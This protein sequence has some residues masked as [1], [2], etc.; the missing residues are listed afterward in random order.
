MTKID[1]IVKPK[2][3]MNIS[4]R[5]IIIALVILVLLIFF[6]FILGSLFKKKEITPQISLTPFPTQ[7]VQKGSTPTLTKQEKNRLEQQVQS[8]KVLTSDQSDKLLSFKDKLP[9]SSS[10]FDIGYS[11]ALGEFFIQKKTPQA[12]DK[13]QQYLK[14]NNMFD[15]FGQFPDLFVI[16]TQP[17]DQAIQ[18][19]EQN[20]SQTQQQN[21][22]QNQQ[23]S[24]QPTSEKSS[25]LQEQ[26]KDIK[27]LTDLFQAFQ[28]LQNSS[29]ENNQS[30]TS[31]T[32]QNSQASSSIPQPLAD[33]FNEAG[34]KVGIAP[35]LIEAIMSKECGY[36]F[37]LSNDEI[38]QKSQPGKGLVPG[39]RCF[40]NG[41][42]YGPMQFYPP[43][44]K[45]Y[46]AYVPGFEGNNNRPYI[47]NIKDSIFAAA[48]MLL[49]NGRP[50][51]PFSWTQAEVY[52]TAAIYSATGP[53]CIKVPTY[54]QDVWNYYTNH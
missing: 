31:Q 39:E 16:T 17:V 47:E 50:A 29:E 3:L 36:I 37:T 42:A 18:Q 23:I 41:F 49:V 4:N 45:T 7:S 21:Q 51:D 11:A 1:K 44:F 19:Q 5:L 20:F 32:P 54:C 24:P 2:T 12:D 26:Q 33:I 43:T 13:L 8:L 15:L 38:S 46:G 28:N 53:N 48:K 25:A 22:K 10:D 27:V 40:T 9:Y 30:G 35:K 34:S 52:K 6:S 14:D